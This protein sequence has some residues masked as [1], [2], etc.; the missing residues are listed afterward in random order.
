MFCAR[1]VGGQPAS[2][3][4]G[5]YTYGER[6]GQPVA[7]SYGYFKADG[8][9]GLSSSFACWTDPASDG[10]P[11]MI[12]QRGRIHP[13]P[14]VPFTR[15][16]RDVGAFSTANIELENVGSDINTVFGPNSPEAA[17]AM[18]NF[19]KAVADFEGIAI[20]CAR[21][22][23]ICGDAGRPDVLTDEPAASAASVRSTP[24]APWP[25]LDTTPCRPPS[26]AS[27]RWPRRADTRRHP[28]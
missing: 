18:A 27:P 12:D 3:C 5:T 9:V 13:A 10:K 23:A 28:R 20:H 16:G 8:T 17:E 1:T 25:C 4:D 19:D 26:A 11:Q 14:W 24:T 22:S 21:D 2:R 15:A 6:H 7:N